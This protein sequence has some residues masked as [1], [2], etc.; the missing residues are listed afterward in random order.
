M[1][2]SQF[3]KG[4]NQGQVAED[5][6]VELAKK[7][8]YKVKASTKK[9]NKQDHIDFFITK[10][11]VTYAVDVKSKGKRGF[12]VEI[13]NN[14][15][16]DGSVFGKADFMC[17]V[18]G[19]VIYL[20]DRLELIEHVRANLQDDTVHQSSV[21]EYIDNPYYRLYTRKKAYGWSDEWLICTSTNIY[22]L[23]KMIWRA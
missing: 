19:G 8:G 15:S 1:Y 6:F 16:G 3:N 14:W 5:K 11:D 7:Q 2:Y 20:I 9:Q 21:F 17:Y 10:D 13:Q 4:I 12:S 23:A 18:D 22:Q